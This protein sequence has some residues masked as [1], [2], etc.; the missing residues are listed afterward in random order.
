M[1]YVIASDG[2]LPVLACGKNS[3]CDN[4]IGQFSHGFFHGSEY[5]IIKVLIN[6]KVILVRFLF[7]F[8]LIDSFKIER[9]FLANVSE[10]VNQTHVYCH[11]AYC[12]R[13]IGVFCEDKNF[14]ILNNFRECR[15]VHAF[16]MTNSMSGQRGNNNIIVNCILELDDSR[17]HEVQHAMVDASTSPFDMS[18]FND[19]TT[20]SLNRGENIINDVLFDERM[21]PPIEA[22]DSDFIDELL[23]DILNGNDPVDVNYFQ[24]IDTD[25]LVYDSFQQ[26]VD[27]LNNTWAPLWPIGEPL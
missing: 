15:S 2:I 9:R 8:L 20:E 24:N 1:S 4:I 25:E 5:G 22:N 12:S 16:S 19:Q 18:A 6:K 17:L 3:L 27:N 11:R 13:E 26:V 7:F 21:L 23:N 10:D 14:V